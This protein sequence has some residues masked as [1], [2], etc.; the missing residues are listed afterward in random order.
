M[1]SS[2]EN[3]IRRSF[4][5][6]PSPP[7]PPIVAFLRKSRGLGQVQIDSAVVALISRSGVQ[8]CIMH[9]LPRMMYSAVVDSQCMD[10]FHV[11]SGLGKPS[12]QVLDGFLQSH[13]L[14]LE[15]LMFLRVVV[16][17]VHLDFDGF[18]PVY[19]CQT[20]NTL[21]MRHKQKRTV[22]YRHTE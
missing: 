12:L 19:N 5:R 1:R 8:F 22:A 14:A 2:H 11:P 6:S 7:S 4:F 18:E 3:E 10:C 21:C 9:L 13:C 16:R 15:S 20:N 17:L